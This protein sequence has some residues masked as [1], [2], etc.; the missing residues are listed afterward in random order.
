MESL[1]IA[2][3]MWKPMNLNSKKHTFL[4]KRRK[5]V[6]GF[7]STIF[8]KLLKVIDISVHY[9]LKRHIE[10]QNYMCGSQLNSI[11]HTLWFTGIAQLSHCSEWCPT[12]HNFNKRCLFVILKV[13]HTWTSTLNVIEAHLCIIYSNKYYLNLFFPQFVTTLYFFHTWNKTVM[14]SRISMCFQTT[15][16]SFYRLFD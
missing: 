2:G 9:F 6:I 1:G 7:L 15:Q 4:L 5:K 10:G 16:I 12:V 3:V 8:G 13:T 14:Q 11:T